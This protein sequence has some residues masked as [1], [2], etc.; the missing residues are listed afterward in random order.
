MAGMTASGAVLPA[1]IAALLSCGLGCGKKATQP[2]AETQDAAR[3]QMAL[4]G[5][6]ELPARPLGLPDPAAFAWRKRE[7]QPLSLIHI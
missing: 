3:A 5:P 2:V 7:G 4:A 6:I 1:C